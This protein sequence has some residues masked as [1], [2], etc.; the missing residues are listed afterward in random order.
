LATREKDKETGRGGDKEILVAA[1]M[2]DVDIDPTFKAATTA[3]L[4]WEM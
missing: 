2:P 1:A 4:K 3:S